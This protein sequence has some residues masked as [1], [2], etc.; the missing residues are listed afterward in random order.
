MKNLFIG[1][2][3]IAAGTGVFFLL[4]KKKNNEP[5]QEF[6]QELLIGKWKTNEKPVKDS[7]SARYQ[8]DFVKDGFFLKKL[9]DSSKV[10]TGYYNWK[11]KNKLI[12]KAN[13]TDTGGTELVVVKLSADSLQLQ[14]ADS[15]I[16]SFSRL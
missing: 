12:W 15:L 8:Y 13:A 1:L 10:D 9:N 5:Q 11:D 16:I 6:Q 7:V 3:I 2:L 14:T 4:Q